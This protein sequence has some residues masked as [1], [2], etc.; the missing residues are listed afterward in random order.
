MTTTSPTTTPTSTAPI[1]D[2]AA[3]VLRWG[4]RVSAALLALGIGLTLFRDEDFSTE[5]VRLVDILPGL[6]DGDSDAVITLSIVSMIA[7]PVAATLVVALGFFAINDRRYG[8]VS[9]A[10]LA[11]LAISIVA[12]FVRQ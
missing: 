5:A 3:S 2:R 6:L 7:T 11:V 9:L 8:K 1:N 12:A 10:V 4:F